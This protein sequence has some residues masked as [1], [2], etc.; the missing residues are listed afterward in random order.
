[1]TGGQNQV[2]NGRGGNF[3]EGS[4]RAQKE[5]RKSVERPQR[6]LRKTSQ[7]AQ[8]ELRKS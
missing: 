1:V 3:T 6:E 2:T 4:E 5:H 8:R 7:R